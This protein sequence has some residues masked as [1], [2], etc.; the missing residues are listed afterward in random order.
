MLTLMYLKASNITDDGF[1]LIHISEMLML[2][3]MRI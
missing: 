2:T 1:G 3:K